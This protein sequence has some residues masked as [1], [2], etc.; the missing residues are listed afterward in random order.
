[1]FKDNR[2]PVAVVAE[3]GDQSIE[4]IVPVENEVEVEVK[5]SKFPVL[6]ELSVKE[7]ILPVAVAEVKAKVPED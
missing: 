2:S 4:S 7:K 5:Y 1:M 3:P 6:K